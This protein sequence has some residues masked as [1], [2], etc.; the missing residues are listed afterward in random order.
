MSIMNE[1]LN[2]Y[3]RP[4]KNEEEEKV[5]YIKLSKKIRPRTTDL[6]PP[7]RDKHNM[8]AK[9]DID[10][11]AKEKVFYEP[12]QRVKDKLDKKVITQDKNM[13]NATSNSGTKPE[14]LYRLFDKIQRK[15][16]QSHDKTSRFFDDAEAKKNKITG[17]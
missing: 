17:K 2:E 13:I 8:V 11:R 10:D 14:S 4:N 7:Q 5:K 3:T 15:T 9:N 1:F 6:Y 12:Y 16:G